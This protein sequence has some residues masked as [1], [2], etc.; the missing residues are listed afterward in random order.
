MG[1]WSSLNPRNVECAY[2]HSDHL[3][4]TITAAPSSPEIRYIKLK[5]CTAAPLAP[6]IR[7]SSALISSTRPRTT[8]AVISTKFVWA[9]SFVRRQVIDDADERLAGV[10]L[11]QAAQH[12]GFGQR[13]ASAGRSRP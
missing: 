9:V 7:L 10:E 3:E 11:A 6:L 2:C 13:A 4:R 5:F 12:F 8:R 1:H